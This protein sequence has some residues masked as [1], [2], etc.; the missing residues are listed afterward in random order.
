MSLPKPDGNLVILLHRFEHSD[1][2]AQKKLRALRFLWL[3]LH[4]GSSGVSDPDGQIQ[5]GNPG[6]EVILCYRQSHEHLGK[7]CGTGMRSHRPQ[8][9]EAVPGDGALEVARI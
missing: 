4:S 5:C 2:P 7:P 3:R 8:S 1:G 6:M 9:L